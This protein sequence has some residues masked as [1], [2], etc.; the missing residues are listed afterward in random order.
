MEQFTVRVVERLECHHL[1]PGPGHMFHCFTAQWDMRGGLA[2]VQG[3]SKTLQLKNT[4]GPVS[5][6]TRFFQYRVP[7]RLYN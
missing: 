7:V 4:G 3:D 1:L 2:P 5:C 6:W